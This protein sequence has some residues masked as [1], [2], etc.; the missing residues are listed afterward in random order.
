MNRNEIIRMA[1]EAGAVIV[2]DAEVGLFGDEKV[3]AFANL[4]AAAEREA[5][6]K[7][8][9]FYVTAS[10]TKNEPGIALI[11]KDYIRN[12]RARGQG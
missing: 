11:I 1:R 4:I 10:N 3:E 6:A 9:E 7:I 8:G 5:C 2:Y 12:I